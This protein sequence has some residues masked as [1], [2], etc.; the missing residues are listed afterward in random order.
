MVLVQLALP[1]QEWVSSV[2]SLMSMTE[3]REIHSSVR[4]NQMYKGNN[5]TIA[6][7][8]IRVQYVSILTVALVATNSVVALLRAVVSILSTLIDIWRDSECLIMVLL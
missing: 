3:K 1:S 5:Y 4:P 2:H 8:F 6:R 7:V